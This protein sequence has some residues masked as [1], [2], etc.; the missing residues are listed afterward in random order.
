MFH[1]RLLGGE[2]GVGEELFV[3]GKKRGTKRRNAELSRPS[4]SP[5]FYTSMRVNI[6][7]VLAYQS[8]WV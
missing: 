5:F 3:L 7:D 1:Y 6:V 4:R 8:R 2:S